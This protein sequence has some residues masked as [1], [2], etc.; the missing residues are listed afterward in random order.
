VPKTSN[1]LALDRAPTARN[2]IGN[3]ERHASQRGCRVQ[4]GRTQVFKRDGAAQYM[5]VYCAGDP[6]FVVKCTNGA[7][8]VL[9]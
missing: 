7:C 3:A 6:A 4:S 1:M 8:K 2:E 9:E 5:R